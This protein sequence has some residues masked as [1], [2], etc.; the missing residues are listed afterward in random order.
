MQLFQSECN[1]C[2]QLRSWWYL[3]WCVLIPVCCDAW[4]TR[5]VNT[6]RVRPIQPPEQPEQVLVKLS[7]QYYYLPLQ[8]TSHFKQRSWTTL[9]DAHRA[10]LLGDL[11][12]LQLAVKLMMYRWSISAFVVTC[13][14]NSLMSDAPMCNQQILQQSVSRRVVAICLI[15][16]HL[17]RRQ[18]VNNHAVF[19]AH[20]H[21]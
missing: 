9:A 6:D 8:T 14:M 18:H 5:L 20:E 11:I 7:A 10:P 3:W 12:V 4:Q 15:F 2:Q 17:A 1:Q 13:W 21:H 16:D 19:L